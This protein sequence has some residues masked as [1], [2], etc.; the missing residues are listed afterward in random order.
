MEISWV[1]MKFR[2]GLWFRCETEGIS[3]DSN[4][5]NAAMRSHPVFTGNASAEARLFGELDADAVEADGARGI[6]W[7]DSD[8]TG[9]IGDGGE[10]GPI[11]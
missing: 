5:A 6:W 4:V 2:G 11:G 10:S 9:A 1:E 3:E 7:R 8:F